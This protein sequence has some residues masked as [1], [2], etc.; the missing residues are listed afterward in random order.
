[1]QLSHHLRRAVQAHRA[2]G[3]HARR[4]LAALETERRERAERQAKQTAAAAAGK[5]AGK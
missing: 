2:Q 5:D 3:E 4:T 1:M